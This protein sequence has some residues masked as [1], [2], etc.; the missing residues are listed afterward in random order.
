M[1]PLMTAPQRYTCVRPF[2]TTVVQAAVVLDGH[3]LLVP[4][5]VCQLLAR[6]CP[7]HKVGVALICHM[8]QEVGPP[9]AGRQRQ[10]VSTWGLYHTSAI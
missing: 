8:L 10:N 9:N 2:I 4:K 5:S 3:V 7:L 6:Y 1:Y